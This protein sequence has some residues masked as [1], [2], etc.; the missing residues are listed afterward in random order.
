MT[1]LLRVAGV[2]V[3]FTAGTAVSYAWAAAAQVRATCPKRVST[4]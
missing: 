1:G 4:L 3:G 2:L